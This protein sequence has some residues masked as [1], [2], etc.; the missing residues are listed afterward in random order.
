MSPSVLAFSLAFFNTATAPVADLSVDGA[1]GGTAR[2]LP[3]GRMDVGVWQPLRYGLTDTLELS[4]H[5]LLATRMPNLRARR[6]WSQA[7]GWDVATL[8]EIAYPTPLLRDFRREGILGLFPLES[9][10][11]H[12]LA[13]RNAILMS[14]PGDSGR[15]FTLSV[16]VRAAATSGRSDFPTLDL[17]VVFPRTA[18]YQGDVVTEIGLATD[19]LVGWGLR[20]RLALDVFLI[21]SDAIDDVEL[22]AEQEAVVTWAAS[23]SFAAHLGYRLVFGRYPFGERTD[24]LPMVDLQWALD[25]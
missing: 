2:T 5:V 24:V 23:E 10:I 15:D 6:R 25:P 20:Y 19:G 1:T 13:M 21:P 3:A 14:S 4:S 22:T 12:I 18:P 16:G 11:P 9:E 8:H 17:P 7:H